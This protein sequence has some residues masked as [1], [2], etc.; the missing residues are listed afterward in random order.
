M[1]RKLLLLT[2]LAVACQ[3]KDD[4]NRM[5]PTATRLS[6]EFANPVIIIGNQAALG[7]VLKAFPALR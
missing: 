1:F 4:A 6:R 7:R 5:P 3:S 2:V